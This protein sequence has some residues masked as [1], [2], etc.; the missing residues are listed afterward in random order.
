MTDTLEIAKKCGAEDAAIFMAGFE[1]GDAYILMPE[2]LQAFREAVEAEYEA[3]RMNQPAVG[4]VVGNGGDIATYRDMPRLPD[5]TLVYAKPFPST[6]QL[7]QRVKELTEAL[8]LADK[9][10]N[11]A[12]PKFNW[13][14]SFLD[15]NAI[16]LLNE[17]PISIKKALANTQGDSK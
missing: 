14:A 16:T 8:Q 3:K 5:Q 1:A 2:E 13:G 10:V 11:E 17:A 6:E 9:M 7:Q 12:L 4:K 15:A